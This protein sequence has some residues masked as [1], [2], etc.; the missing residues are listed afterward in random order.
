MTTQTKKSAF[1]LDV[2]AAR[3]FVR[4]ECD[5]RLT[6][7]N[8][9]AKWT[10]LEITAISSFRTGRLNLSHDAILTLLM[11]ADADVRKFIK[12]RPGVGK[13]AKHKDT[14]DQRQIRT[15]EGFLE[16][17]NLTKQDGESAVD[18]MIRIIGQFRDAG[19]ALDGVVEGNDE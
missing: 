17:A 14:P 19:I 10:G 13:Q 18:A 3:E 9:I 8:D 11:W 5:T 12:R 16:R 1:Y 15:A 4:R 2:E 7:L 6:S